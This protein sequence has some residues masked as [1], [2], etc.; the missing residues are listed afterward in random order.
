MADASGAALREIREIENVFIPLAD[1]TR[2]AARIW[3]PT[4]AE[5]RP[6]PAILEY[7]PYRKRDG[8]SGRDARR[9]PY[10]ARHGYASVRVDIRGSGES[11]GLP[12]DEYVKQEQDDC[13]EVI[14]WLAA[15]TWC[16]GA[17]GMVGI[18]WGG[19]NG[20]Q[21]AARRPPALKAV[22]TLC[23]TDD[24][25]ADDIHFMG[26]CLLRDN[27]TWGSAMFSHTTRPPDPALVGDR[28]R[29]MWIERLDN[30]PFYSAIWLRHQRRDA[31]WQHGSVCE[32]WGGITCPVY[33]VGGWAD[34]YS[35]AIPRLLANL[36]GPRKGLIGPWAHVYPQAGMPGP[37]IGFLQETLRWWDHWLKGIDTGIMAEP[38]LRA[39]MQDSHRPQPDY[40][41][42]HG[43]WVG[44]SSWPSAHIAS[45]RRWLTAAGIADEA[46]NEAPLLVCS[47]ECTGVTSGTWC[48]HGASG[49]EPGDQREDDGRSVVFDS[50]PLAADLPIL[51]APVIELDV[52]ADRPNA[53]LI[54]RLCEVH[55][56]GASTRVSYAVLNLTHR[57]SHET[58]AALVPG[59]R[60]RVRLRLNDVGYRFAAG[61]RIRVAL[62][63]SYW[64]IV[65]PSPERAAVT[66]TA[67]TATLDLPVRAPRPADAMLPPFGPPE[68]SSPEV[69]TRLRAGG[70]ERSVRR[71][72]ITGETLFTTDDDDGRER[73]EAIGLEIANSRW[74]CFRVRDEDPLSARNETLWHKEM[75]RGDWQISTRTRV[76]MTATR[77]HFRMTAELDAFEG[78][79]R[80]YSRNWDETI[81]RDLT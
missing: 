1:G 26:G 48:A 7:I 22:I 45:A 62:S 39:W 49:D 12:L 14:A 15:Q 10:T 77:T 72:N 51:G 54:A 9:H 30:L 20:L 40:A 35:N 32:D 38:M 5:T 52:A 37:A 25:Y 74:Q 11:D 59:Q 21:V 67:G 63:T 18:S 50:A 34:G 81:P 8:T 44:E 71:D 56:D 61:N 13:L 27:H 46:G 19:F 42:K 64:P 66:V 41:E 79:Q 47:P 4:D 55:P 70:R 58:P 16:S 43:H 80:I 6:V 31:F 60:Y 75:G 65:W 73:I 57:D 33:A 78:G 36:N 53:K 23:S 17:V 76:V 3:L 28:W 24:R 29:E 2:L 68:M 69:R